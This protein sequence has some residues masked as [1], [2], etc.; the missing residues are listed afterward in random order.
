LGVN[1]TR[2]SS[3]RG[4]TCGLTSRKR[5]RHGGGREQQQGAGEAH[6]AISADLA[7]RNRSLTLMKG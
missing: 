5:D 1:W 2:G 6:L 7:K 3:F 4:G